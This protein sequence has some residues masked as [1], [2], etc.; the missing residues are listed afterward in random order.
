MRSA[1]RFTRFA[2]APS[3]SRSTSKAR[4]EGIPLLV[5]APPTYPKQPSNILQVLAI[6]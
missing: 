5:I 3:Q 2:I 6:A 1:L 4:S